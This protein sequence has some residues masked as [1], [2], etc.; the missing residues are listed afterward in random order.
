M[1]LCS[2]CFKSGLEVMIDIKDGL[3]TCKR[4]FGQ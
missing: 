1:G 3:P 4:C 2:K